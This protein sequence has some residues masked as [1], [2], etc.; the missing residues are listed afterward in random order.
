MAHKQKTK[1]IRQV[2]RTTLERE[3]LQQQQQQQM[4]AAA[5][6]N[7]NVDDMA[8]MSEESKRAAAAAKQGER[9]LA[10]QLGY[11][12]YEPARATAGQARTATTTAQHGSINAEGAGGGAGAGQT[13]TLPTVAPPAQPTTPAESNDDDYDGNGYSF[14]IEPSEEFSQALA[15]MLS[16]SS[17]T[18][19]ASSCTIMS[20]LLINATTKGQ[21]KGEDSAKFRRVRLE[22][23]KIKAALVDVPGAIE[24]MLA[25]GFQLD[26]QDG[27]SVLV[28]PANNTGPEWL[29]TALKQMEHA[30]AASN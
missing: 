6:A 11:N 15:T 20:K 30:A 14:P 10:Q 9:Q 26:E 7:N 1:P 3:K 8:P 25:T 17:Q 18:I 12:P 21:A 22:N 28:F 19:V 5:S 16:S 2:T 24:V 23:A 4:A 29:P 27:E 13:T